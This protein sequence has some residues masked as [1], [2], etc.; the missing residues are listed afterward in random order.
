MN[1]ELL[2]LYS[3]YL[4]STFS[5]TTA[6]GLSAMTGGAISHD[7]ITR[8]LASEEFD[9]A[10]LW[11]LVKP[12]VRRLE[13]EDGV[14]IID[15]TIEEKPYTD[16]SELICWHYDHSQGR[17][18]KGLNLLSALYQTDDASIPVAFEMVKKTEW[19]FNQKRKKWQRKSP[20]TKNEHYRQMLAACHANRIEFRYVLSDV[21]YSSSEN[22]GYIK[23]GLHKGGSRQGVHHAAQIE[24]QGGSLGRRQTAG[25]IRAS[26]GPPTR[27]EHHARSLPGAGGVPFAFGKASLQKRGWH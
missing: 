14:L 16:E 9:S 4:L 1:T 15:D 10:A 11:H 8:F 2:E 26:C 13:G 7:R 3:D 12:M 21:W 27:A 20:R 24:P 19:V 6:T 25:S 22:M 18:V 23:Y 5:H 17:S